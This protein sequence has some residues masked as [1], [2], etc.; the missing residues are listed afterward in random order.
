MGELES[1]FVAARIFLGEPLSFLMNIVMIK[2]PTFSCRFVLR[3]C[4]SARS[5]L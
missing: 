5:T 1:K 3:L 4:I 2:A